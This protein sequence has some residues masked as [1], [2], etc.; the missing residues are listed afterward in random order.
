ML[1]HK[2]WLSKVVF[3]FIIVFSV[4]VLTVQAGSLAG[5]WKTWVLTSAD[6]FRV[7]APPDEATKTDEIA[8]LMDM[9]SQRDDAALQ[10]ITYWNAGPPSYRWNKIATDAMLVQGMPANIALRDL[11]LLNVA[12]YDATVAAW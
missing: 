3:V 12:I 7:D 1:H 5:T 8:Q 10:Q 11:A 4:G 2:R 9:V 6:Q